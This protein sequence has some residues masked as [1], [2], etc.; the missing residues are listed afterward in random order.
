MHTD[1][2]GPHLRW[3]DPNVVMSIVSGASSRARSSSTMTPV[4]VCTEPGEASEGQGE[5]FQTHQIMGAAFESGESI[6]QQVAAISAGLGSRSVSPLGRASVT[7][8]SLI[9][10]RFAPYKSLVVDICCAT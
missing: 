1:K 4:G 9:A 10:E 6:N 8:N 2:K 3:V 5:L 7:R